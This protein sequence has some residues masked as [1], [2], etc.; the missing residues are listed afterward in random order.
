MAAQSYTTV[1]ADDLP[2]V[3]QAT[4]TL[5]D[6]FPG[7][8]VL[9]H[10]SDGNA[11][12]HLI[13]NLVPDVALLDWNLSRL[14]TSEVLRLVRES[15]LPTKT[16]VLSARGD[17]KTVMQ[18][19]RSGANGFALKSGSARHLEEALRQVLAGGVY[20]SPLLE[21]Y[22][23]LSPTR[24]PPSGDPLKCLSSREH[25]VFT[26]LVEGVRAK[27]IAARLSLS[28]KTIDTYRANLMRKLDIHDMPALVKLAI[29]RKVTHVAG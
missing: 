28:P 9:G 16:I 3:A 13:E 10:C 18:V 14:M 4:A 2:L 6:T 25:Q 11:A 17:R 20:V 15:G 29:Q 19:L 1:I 24:T 5:C 21:S 27:E 26:L 23:S 12:W 7:C 8:L 22:T